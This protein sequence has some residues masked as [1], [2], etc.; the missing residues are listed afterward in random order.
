MNL[1]QTVWQYLF[2]QNNKMVWL[3]THGLIN[4][5]FLY[6]PTAVVSINLTNIH[7]FSR[8]F[9][10]I[11]GNQRE[12]C[13]ESH[14][15]QPPW[16]CL[17]PYQPLCSLFSCWCLLW[18]SL[19]TSLQLLSGHPVLGCQWW[20]TSDPP[21]SCQHP[22]MGVV[23][24]WCLSCFCVFT[25]LIRIMITICWSNAPNIFHNKF[26][27]HYI[28]NFNNAKFNLQYS[29][30]MVTQELGQEQQQI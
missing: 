19:H 22:V 1:C 10:L 24:N 27:R 4:Y 29:T 23:T 15:P 5:L 20:Q 3:G 13:S 30:S 16:I 11:H 17:R 8:C 18:P 12:L 21:D 9:T 6:S 25:Q 26:A 14:L 2:R 7:H 28:T